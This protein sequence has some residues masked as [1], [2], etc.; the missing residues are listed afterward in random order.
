MQEYKNK[1]AS[2]DGE[3]K[4][5]NYSSARFYYRSASDILKWETYPQLQLKEIDRL[6]AEKL[7]ES[8]QRLFRE[9]QNKADEAFNRKEYP[10]ARFYYNKAIEISQSDHITSRLNEIESIMN[11]SESKKVNAAYDDCI[12]KGNEAR[13][14][15]NSSIARFYYQKA[16]SLK[17]DEN[18][19][20]EEL[21][22]IDSGAVNP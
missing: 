2:A 22:K 19:P 20:K 5:K 11:G 9:N 16:N 13:D 4:A 18:Y 3:M 10:T 15:K 17:P 1:I 8:D 6:V 21:R 14:Q 7:S 12:K